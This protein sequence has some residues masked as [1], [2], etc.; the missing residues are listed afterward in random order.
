MPGDK[1]DPKKKKKYFKQEINYEWCKG[2][3]I[4]IH[5]CP[6]KVYVANLLGKPEIVDSDLCIGCKLCEIRCP[7]FA[8]EI[9]PREEKEK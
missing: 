2:C 1:I 3:G 7:D 8:I 5:F 4:C 6:K 9:H